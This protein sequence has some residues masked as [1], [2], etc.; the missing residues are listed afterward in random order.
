MD[1]V[2]RPKDCEV[3]AVVTR[4]K[5]NGVIAYVPKL[6]MK[7][8]VY[9]VSQA[10]QLLLPPKLAGVRRSA[11]LY[12]DVE[13]DGAVESSGAWTFTH[14]LTLSLTH[15]HTRSLTST[16]PTHCHTSLSHPPT[17]LPTHPLTHALAHALIH[18]L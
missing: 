18:S 17:H 15:S 13:C 1:R 6:G 11:K 4:I 12:A 7:G 16:P 5:E 8:P 9:L 2:D 10:G 14:T 3:D